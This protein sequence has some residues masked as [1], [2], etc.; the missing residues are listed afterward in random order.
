MNRT[1][2]QELILEAAKN[3]NNNLMIKAFA[4]CGKTATLEMIERV[5]KTKPILYLCFNK[6]NA[7]EAKERMLSTTTV[8]TFNSLGHRIWTNACGRK[9]IN[10]NPRKTQDILK[11]IIE[12]VPRREQGEFWESYWSVIHG[13]AMAKALGYVPDGKFSNAKRLIA[14]ANFHRSLDEAPDDLTADLIDTTLTASITAAYEGHIDYNDQIYMPALFGGTYPRFPFVMVDESQ[15]LSP[16]NH[17]MLEKLAK[18]RL[19]VVGD[20]YQSIYQFRGAVASGMDRLQEQYSPQV[21]DLSISFRCPSEIVRY[22]QRR[23]PNFKWFREG[24]NVSIPDHLNPADIVDGTAIICRNNAPLFKV[25]LHLLAAG[26][27]VSVAGSDIGPKLI[28]LM[29]RL[30]PEDLSQ[31]SVLSAIDDWLAE[32]LVRESKTAP[33]LADCMRVF[34]KFGSNLAQ[35]IR[36]AEHLFQQKGTIRLLTGHKAKGLEWDSV[37]HLD[38]YLCRRG[39]NSATANEEQDLNLDYVIT[40]RSKDRLVEIDS[41]AIRW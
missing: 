15:D 41:E 8:R 19:A 37:I 1:P 29:K 10:L 40:T 35:A 34:A 4:G 5:V 7:E 33:D 39:I 38:P 3:S 2:E 12:S 18:G 14:R 17:A 25:A 9:S 28:A 22:A 20:P 6:K 27:P 13:V 11:S 16:V 21:L 32:R 26:R 30:G 31:A 24:G 23:V 36:Y